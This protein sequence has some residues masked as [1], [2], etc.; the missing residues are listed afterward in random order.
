LEATGRFLKPPDLEASMPSAEP[1]RTAEA[2][3]RVLSEL[4]KVDRYERRAAASR[5]RAVRELSAMSGGD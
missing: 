4:L 2:V 5:N 1:E 3:A